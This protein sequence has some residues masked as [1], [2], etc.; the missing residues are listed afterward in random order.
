MFDVNVI[1]SDL[2]AFIIVGAIVIFAITVKH[3]RDCRSGYRLSHA[4]SGH[5]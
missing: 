4:R 1:L 3:V 2:P 5:A